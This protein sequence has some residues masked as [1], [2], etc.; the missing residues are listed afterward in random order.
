MVPGRIWTTKG[1]GKLMQ[2]S[3]QVNIF[4]KKKQTKFCPL[5]SFIVI[6][7]VYPLCSLITVCLT[8]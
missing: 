3:V 5:K 2:T 6:N 1:K 4:V 7:N 8:K